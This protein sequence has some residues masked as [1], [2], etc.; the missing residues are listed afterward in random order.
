MALNQACE[1]ELLSNE[2][3]LNGSSEKAVCRILEGKRL[4][5]MKHAMKKHST[6]V[7]NQR[8]KNTNYNIT[9]HGTIEAVKKRVTH[10]Q[11]QPQQLPPVLQGGLAAGD[12]VANDDPAAAATGAKIQPN[13]QPEVILEQI[14]EIFAVVDETNN[15]AILTQAR[16]YDTLAAMTRSL[17]QDL[18]RKGYSK[19]ICLDSIIDQLE[20]VGRWDRKEDDDTPSD[21]ESKSSDFV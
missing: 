17:V 2:S 5:E 19:T 20:A 10:M 3:Y 6:V 15:D 8:N 16:N 9:N 4:E 7:Y 14:A 21:S 13:I 18:Q 11:P 1:K 12:V